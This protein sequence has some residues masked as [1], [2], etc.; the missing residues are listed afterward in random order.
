MQRFLIVTVSGKCCLRNYNLNWL[1]KVAVN[2]GKI[3]YH[4]RIINKRGAIGGIEI[5]REN[6]NT[7]RKTASVLCRPQIPHDLIWD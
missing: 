3:Y 6:R 4:D 5:G 1:F 2:I 7:R